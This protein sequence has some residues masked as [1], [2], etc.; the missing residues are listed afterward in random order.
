M[1]DREYAPKKQNKQEQESCTQ[2]DC[3]E[4]HSVFMTLTALFLAL[5][6]VIPFLFTPLAVFFGFCALISKI[7]GFK[8]KNQ[9]QA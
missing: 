9:T 8:A 2:E 7:V 6:F 3:E 5:S 1:L 4:S